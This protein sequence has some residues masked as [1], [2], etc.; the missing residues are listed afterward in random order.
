MAGGEALLLSKRKGVSRADAGKCG[1]DGGGAGEG[2]VLI[3]I[4]AGSYSHHQKVNRVG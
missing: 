4:K 1:V 3:V 2:V